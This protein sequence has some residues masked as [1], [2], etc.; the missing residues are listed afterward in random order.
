MIQKFFRKA[1]FVFVGCHRLDK[2]SM[3]VSNILQIN[4]KR[5]RVRSF[6]TFLYEF[7]CWILLVALVKLIL[8]CQYFSR[9]KIR[10]KAEAILI[11]LWQWENN[12]LPLWSISRLEL[13]ELLVIFMQFKCVTISG[14]LPIWSL[15]SVPDASFI[16]SSCYFL[17]I[18]IPFSSL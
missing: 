2:N 4:L 13:E 1:L 8:P 17:G 15:K 9:T 16:F 7:C 18:L 10:G 12:C 3:C 11:F 5:E 14:F 6:L